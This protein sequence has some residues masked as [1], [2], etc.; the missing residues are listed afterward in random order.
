MTVLQFQYVASL[1]ECCPKKQQEFYTPVA[2]N[3]TASTYL[4]TQLKQTP[5]Q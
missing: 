4:T 3:L 2:E 1:N 5:L